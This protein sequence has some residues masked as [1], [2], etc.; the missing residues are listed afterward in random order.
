MDKA[1]MKSAMAMQIKAQ[2]TG[3][4]GE[5]DSDE[6]IAKLHSII[7]LAGALNVE[8]FII[9]ISLKELQEAQKEYIKLSASE[10]E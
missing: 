9:R 10:E 3:V 7:E 5:A 6:C 8:D 1:A 2:I 4:F